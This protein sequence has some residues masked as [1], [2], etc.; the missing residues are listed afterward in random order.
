[1]SLRELLEPDCQ[2]ANSLMRLGNHIRN[3]NAFK[4]EGF[5]PG[6]S[7]VNRP[8]QFG[9]DQLVQ[10]FLGQIAPPQSFRM[11]ALLQ[12]MRE[13]DAQPYHSRMVPQAPVVIE[14]VNSGFDWANEFSGGNVQYQ[15][16]VDEFAAIESK[17]LSEFWD[18]NAQN[19]DPGVIQSLNDKTWQNEFLDI[20]ESLQQMVSSSVCVLNVVNDAT[21]Y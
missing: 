2:G 9:S 1:M 4:D 3:D 17:N 10:E 19:V 15:P 7:F 11:D 18:R 12:E 21:F 13:I 20:G 16:N 8:Q 6:T 5:G 14:E